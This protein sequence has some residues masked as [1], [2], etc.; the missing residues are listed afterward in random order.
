MQIEKPYHLTRKAEGRGQRAE[1]TANNGAIAL[2]RPSFM[3]DRLTFYT[4]PTR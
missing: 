3:S 1:G 2:N 4:V